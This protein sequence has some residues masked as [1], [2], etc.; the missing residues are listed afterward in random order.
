MQLPPDYVK[1]EDESVDDEPLVDEPY[2]DF[3]EDEWK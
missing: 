1:K 2:E 3:K